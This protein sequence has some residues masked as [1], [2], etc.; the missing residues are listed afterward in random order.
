MS[1][2]L[3][4]LVLLSM[5]MHLLQ[6]H[7]GKHHNGV[8]PL[9]NYAVKFTMSFLLVCF[10]IIII[11]KALNGDM[12]RYKCFRKLSLNFIRNDSRNRPKLQRPNT[13]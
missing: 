13:I 6:L 12:T 5:F 10:A 11:I 2:C 8:Y 4:I 9:I 1:E 7:T 3:G